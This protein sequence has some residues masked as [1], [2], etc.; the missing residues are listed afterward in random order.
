[1]K[2]LT[3]E[4]AA[5]I[6]GVHRKTLSKLIKLGQAPGFKLGGVGTYRIPESQFND[7]LEG[8]PFTAGRGVVTS[9]LAKWNGAGGTR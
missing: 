9:V 7:W 2:V 5:D 1:M 3:L 6:L 8:K 4:E